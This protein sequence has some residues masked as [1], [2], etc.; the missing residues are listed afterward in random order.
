MKIA[1]FGPGGNSALFASKGYKSSLDA[2]AWVKNMG[3]DAYEYECGKGVNASLETFAQI[4]LNAAQLGIKT[5]LHAPYFISLSSVEPEKRM[6]SV[7][8]ILQSLS[9]A[10]ALGA[11]TIV[12]HAGSASKIDRET[13]LSYA[14]DTIVKALEASQDLGLDDI[15]IGLETMGKVNQL[16]TL[17][18]II[19]LCQIDSR[20]SPVIDFGH[21][22][23][24]S[25]GEDMSSGDKVKSAFEKVSNALGAEKAEKMHCHFS[26][27]EFSN[28]GEVK[29]LTFENTSFGPEPSMFARSLSELGVAPTIIC[30][31]A[32]TQ[33]IDALYLKNEYLKGIKE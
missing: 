23:A 21:L 11:D 16:G 15:K 19:K 2:P 17:D 3:L 8:Y 30:E 13:A 5:S 7:K 6:N 14:S 12:V 10:K 26:C 28:G 32:G 22:Y 31:S 18:E 33:D 1:K 25:H 27:I 4:G 20:L 24:R 29:H 9:A